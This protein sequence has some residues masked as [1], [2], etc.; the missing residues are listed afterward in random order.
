MRSAKAAAEGPGD[1]LSLNYTLESTSLLHGPVFAI[2]AVCINA[3]AMFSRISDA[4]N[5]LESSLDFRIPDGERYRLEQI[6]EKRSM[7]STREEV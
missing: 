3:S 2:L 5:V 7:L 1:F 4:N 6:L